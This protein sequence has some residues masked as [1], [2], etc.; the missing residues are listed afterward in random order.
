MKTLFGQN[1]KW[2]PE[3]EAL[4]EE[5]DQ[6]LSPIIKK[7]LAKGYCLTQIGMVVKSE[8]ANII[9]ATEVSSWK[10]E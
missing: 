2:S 3:G 5:V 7:A 8:V 9:F 1:S 4:A 6:A 10:E